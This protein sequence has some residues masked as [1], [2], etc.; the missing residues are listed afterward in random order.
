MSN[1]RFSGNIFSMLK[2]SLLFRKEMCFDG[3]ANDF[4]S[5]PS[6][7]FRSYQEQISNKIAWISRVKLIICV[8]NHKIVSTFSP[9]CFFS[10]Q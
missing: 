10:D 4:S 1:F 6:P 8:K 5:S 3:L 7:P 9:K 2:L